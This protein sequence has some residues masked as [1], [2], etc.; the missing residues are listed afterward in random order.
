MAERIIIGADV[1]KPLYTFDNATIK[2]C[3]CVLS[4]ALV[5]DQIAVDQFMPV[6]YSASYVQVNFVPAGS[7]RLIT[8]DGKVFKCFSGEQGFLDTLPYS[9]PIWYFSNDVLMGKFYSQRVVRTAKTYFD[10]VAVSAIGILD[11][12]DHYGGLYAGQKFQDVANDIIGGQFAFSCADNVANIQ[13]FGW[14]PIGTRRSNLHQLLFACGVSLGKDSNGDIYF[15]FPDAETYKDIPKSR[16]FLG[17]SIDYMT[18]ATTVNITE[19]AYL[20]L[21]T[22]QAVTLF[23]NT[24]GSGV[25]DNTFVRFTVAPVRDLAVSGSLTIVESSV[26]YAIVSGTGTLTGRPYTHTAKVVNRS[27]EGVKGVEKAVSVT[28]ATLVSVANSENVAQRVLS[29]YSAAKTIASDIVLT[30]EKP[31]DLISF[32][33][34][35]E[36]PELAFL[37]SMEIN[38]SSFLRA[39]CDLVTGYVPAGQGNNYTEAIVL[40][41][42]GEYTFDSDNAMVVLIGGGDGA[43]SG[44]KG[45]DAQNGTAL[46]Y[47][48]EIGYGGLPG[49]R[50]EGGRIYTVKLTGVKGKAFAYKC[51]TA[52]VGGVSDG[53]ENVVAGTSGTDTT[54]GSYT[55]ANGERSETGYVNLF[56]GE[57][58]A[59]PGVDGVPGGDGTN[60]SNEGK[61]ITFDGKTWIPGRQGASYSTNAGN[62]DGG[63]GGGPAVG[64]NGENGSDGRANSNGGYGGP[65]GDGGTPM[66]GKK[67]ASLGS[68]G[69]G[70]HGGGGGGN[71]GYGSGPEDKDRMSNGSPGDGAPGSNGGDAAPGCIILYLQKEV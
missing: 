69:S 39:S 29:Y 26:N 40:T 5:G 27:V 67:G 30:N 56:T 19:H 32:V 43:E 50:G 36:E 46:S 41:G 20:P 15:R 22:D 1:N 9:T 49:K 18:P 51:G 52:G 24:D 28:D 58:Y 17:G 35:Y 42:E 63:Y 70:G 38:A 59:L 4:S 62:G 11:G 14:L 16:I 37:S 44:G 7:T 12:Q 34:P 33:N 3:V 57:V 53:T 64:A 8:A 21:S 2:E 61:S 23:D 6:V 68:G 10:I 71:G 25:A 65:G 55:S 45:T 60:S 47:D 54:F 66:P 48:P 13:I 31:G